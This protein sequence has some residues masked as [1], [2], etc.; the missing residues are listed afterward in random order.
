M[1]TVDIPLIGEQWL[2]P[3]QLRDQ[4]YRQIFAD[5]YNITY[6]FYDNWYN[7]LREEDKQSI[8]RVALVKSF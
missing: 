4:L 3:N 7:A 5:P 6:E 1:V 2:M 8:K